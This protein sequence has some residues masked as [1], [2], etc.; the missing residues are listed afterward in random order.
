MHVCGAFEFPP[1]FFAQYSNSHYRLKKAR[2]R[3]IK[4]SRSRKSIIQFVKKN[5]LSVERS[6]EIIR[7]RYVGCG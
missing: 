6:P 3:D 1:F 4:R 5:H 7:E 2:S